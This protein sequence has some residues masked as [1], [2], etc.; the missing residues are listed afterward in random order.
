[1]KKLFFLLLF[2]QIAVLAQTKTITNLNSFKELEVNNGIEITLIK[3]DENKV[4]IKGKK[5]E[6]IIIKVTDEV[7]KVGLPFYKILTETK[8]TVFYKEDILKITAN[9]TSIVKGEN[10]QQTKIT[11]IAKEKSII[12]LSVNVSNINVFATSSGIITLQGS[13]NN[14]N[15]DVE[16]Y[17]IYEGFGLNV[18]GD[19]TVSAKSG[20]KAEVYSEKKL[21]PNVSFGGSIFYKGNPVISQDKKVNGGIIQKRE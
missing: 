14:Q 15:V 13:A 21:I 7:L 8:A 5:V 9:N 16:L 6:Q 10:L 4:E 11:C 3:S 1:M 2:I 17:G 19:T 20:A 18:K 12:E